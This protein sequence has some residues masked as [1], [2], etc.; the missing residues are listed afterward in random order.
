MQQRGLSVV[1]PVY[2]SEETLPELVARLGVVLE[3][4]GSE[5]ELV[6]VDDGSR[7]G[8]WETIKR[9]SRERAWVRG[10]A[11]MRNCGQHNALLAG[12]RAARYDVIATLDDDLQNPPE[13][14]PKLLEELDR[15]YDV[16]YG[17]PER[18]QHGLWRDLASQV[19]KLA[20]QSAMG[21]KTARNVSAFR[22][23]RT[24]L[25]KAFAQYHS[26]YVSIDVLL[27]WGTARFSAV[28]VRHDPRRAGRSQY[29]FLKLV[30]H[31]MNMLTGFSAVPL[32]LA[33]L[34]GF[35]FTLFG[36]GVLVYVMSRVLIYGRVVPG[37]AFLASTMA[38]FSGAQLFA[39]GILGEYLARMHFRSMEKPPYVVAESTEEEQKDAGKGGTN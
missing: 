5:F 22:V 25:R 27:T 7:D 11:L 39:L 35:A 8:S 18:Q 12:I 3:K 28:R 31:A 6:L 38:I 17:T 13:E 4:L 15:G 29:T 32:K 16:V 9:L 30:T 10:L 24:R 20:L 37:F 2:N 21:V 33:S 14:L 23:F 36:I 34:T 19:T 26:P 1:V